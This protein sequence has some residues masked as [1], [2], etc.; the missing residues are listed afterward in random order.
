MTEQYLVVSSGTIIDQNQLNSLGESDWIL[1]HVIQ[2]DAGLVWY[3]IFRKTAGA[4][5]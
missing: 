3:H 1:E 4:P 2:P 5:E